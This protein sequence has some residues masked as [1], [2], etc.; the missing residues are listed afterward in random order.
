VGCVGE[1]SGGGAVGEGGGGD[2]AYV[3][4][5]APNAHADVGGE[6]LGQRRPQRRLA[7][8]QSSAQG[9]HRCL[10]ASRTRTRHYREYHHATHSPPSPQYTIVRHYF[11][12]S[13][14]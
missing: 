4:L 14:N 7:A 8:Q 6:H 10:A 13:K 5:G 11:K 3:W 9:A 1:G 12:I 2:A